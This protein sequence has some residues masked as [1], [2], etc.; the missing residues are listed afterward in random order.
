M[1]ISNYTNLRQ[2]LKGPSIKA[3][4]GPINQEVNL[5]SRNISADAGSSEVKSVAA[6]LP[7]RTRSSSWLCLAWLGPTNNCLVSPTQWMLLHS[8]AT[9]LDFY[10]DR[11]QLI[12]M[13]GISILNWFYSYSDLFCKLHIFVHSTFSLGKIC[14]FFCFCVMSIIV[15]GMHTRSKYL[16]I[17]D[18]QQISNAC[19]NFQKW[20]ERRGG[21]QRGFEEVETWLIWGNPPAFLMTILITGEKSQGQ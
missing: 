5:N 7:N 13:M 11:S 15:I 10:C 3:T 12:L 2:N 1:S 14:S 18:F 6:L 16:L 4:L 8:P 19:L 17:K 21:G 9:D 20:G